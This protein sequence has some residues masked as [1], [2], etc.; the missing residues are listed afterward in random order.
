RKR[1]M[2]ADLA[3]ARAP[4]SASFGSSGSS[5]SPTTRISSRSEVIVG[6]PAKSFSG[7]RPANQPWSSDSVNGAGAVLS[8]MDYMITQQAQCCQG[9]GGRRGSSR[10]LVRG[11]LEDRP[12]ANVVPP[13]CEAEADDPDHGI[14]P[15]VREPLQ[16]RDGGGHVVAE[17]ERDEQAR[18]AR[19]DGAES[20]GREA[21]PARALRHRV[22]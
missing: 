19:L 7:R 6:G 1:L 22:D 9:L 8:F 13:P 4:S 17:P 18:R 3:A 15:L 21:Q 11:D 10:E 16:D 14:E 20:A 2:R 12:S 5:M